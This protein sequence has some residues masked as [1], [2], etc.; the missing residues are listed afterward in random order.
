MNLPI[1]PFATLHS[2]LTALLVLAGT[3]CATKPPAKGGDTTTR[4]SFTIAGFGKLKGRGETRQDVVARFGPPLAEETA[5]ADAHYHIL[6][7]PIAGESEKLLLL[8]DGDALLGV[9]RERARDTMNTT[10]QSHSRDRSGRVALF[11]SWF[12]GKTT[13]FVTSRGKLETLPK[14]SPKKGG[15]AP[16]SEVQAEAIALE[17]RQRNAPELSGQPKVQQVVESPGFPGVSF[18]IVNLGMSS[19]SLVLHQV[20]VLMDGTVVAGESESGQ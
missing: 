11:S 17:W 14:W 18:Y 7:Y 16:L 20:V 6:T 13:C 9:F 3:S 2:L 4:D 8:F 5:S 10:I 12:E 15:A 1:F 19:A